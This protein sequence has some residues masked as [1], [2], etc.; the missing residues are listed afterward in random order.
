MLADT[1]EG[2]DLRQISPFAG[3]LS[4]EDRLVAMKK[5]QLLAK[6]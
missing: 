3:A 4:P 5:A 6:G 2:S 1:E